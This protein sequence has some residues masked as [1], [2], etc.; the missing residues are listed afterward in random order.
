MLEGKTK[1]GFKFKIDERVLEDWRLIKNIQLAESGDLNE[2]VVG[3][4][5]LVSML[6]GDNEPKLMDHIAKKNG[7]FIPTEALIEELA[8]IITNSKELKNSKSSPT[9]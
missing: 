7:G 9:S 8:E 4:S 2:K 3:V 5:S 6:L 1:S